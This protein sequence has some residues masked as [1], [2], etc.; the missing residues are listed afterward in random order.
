MVFTVGLPFAVL[1][2]SYSCFFY[3]PME[4]DCEMSPIGSYIGT[5]GAQLLDLIL[6]G[7]ETFRGDVMLEE[8]DHWGVC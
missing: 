8:V 4:F 2:Y 1:L 6:E 7:R 3:P 5:L